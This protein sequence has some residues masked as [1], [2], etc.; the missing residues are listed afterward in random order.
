MPRSCRR[1]LLSLLWIASM[2]LGAEAATIL[3]ESEYTSAGTPA[4]K[5]VLVL[6]G[7]PPEAGRHEPE[8][9]VILRNATADRDRNIAPTAVVLRGVRWDYRADDRSWHS[10]SPG[11]VDRNSDGSLLHDTSAG[12]LTDIAFERGLLRPGE[13]IELSL[14]LTP[15]IFG[16]HDL[17]VKY[18]LLPADTWKSDTLVQESVP[19]KSPGRIKIGYY[20]ASAVPHDKRGPAAVY[21]PT[22]KPGSATPMAIYDGVIGFKIPM[23]PEEPKDSPL[24]GI[25]RKAGIDLLNES[26]WAFRKEAMNAWIFVRDDGRAVA[27]K[28]EEYLLLPD[29]DVRVPEELGAVEDGST[30]MYL[31]RAGFEGLYEGLEPD[32]AVPEALR[33]PSERLWPLMERAAAQGVRLER[34]SVRTPSAGPLNV[35]SCGMSVHSGSEPPRAEG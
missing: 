23:R 12:G 20:P 11:R 30:R 6:P 29:M 19:P 17:I 22:S 18:G 2:P 8:I 33:L 9:R 15:Q 34:V 31:R 13:S 5:A 32:P 27:L 28:G 3:P 1:L 14:P 25:A 4:I 7:A 21:R 24:V 10:R 16:R 26:W 35:V